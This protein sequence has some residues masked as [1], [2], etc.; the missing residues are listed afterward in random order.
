MIKFDSTLL[1]V[2]RVSL[3]RVSYGLKAKVVVSETA[4]SHHTVSHEIDHNLARTF[5]R[6]HSQ[7][8]YPLGCAALV[9]RYDDQ[10]LTVVR[11]PNFFVNDC[12]SAAGEKWAESVEN[13]FEYF[14]DSIR[15]LFDGHYFDGAN[16]ID[17]K[18]VQMV[19]SEGGLSFGTAKSVKI[20]S[21]LQVVA[22]NKMHGS[23]VTPSLFKA[24]TI[25]VMQRDAD[26][27]VMIGLDRSAFAAMIRGE[28][29]AKDVAAHM[30][31]GMLNLQSIET[32]VTSVVARYD[33]QY[34]SRFNLLDVMKTLGTLDLGRI[35]GE[36]KRAM[37]T[38]NSLNLMMQTLFDII[39]EYETTSA[40]INMFRQYINTVT[41]RGYEIP[42]YSTA[43]FADLV[44]SVMK[45]GA[46]VDSVPVIDYNEAFSWIQFT[47]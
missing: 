19:A 44:Q 21:L 28:N 23:Q 37:I 29:A 5:K 1:S 10:I 34:I 14:R 35:D 7:T 8:R 25:A 18:S 46:T 9:I 4:G 43:A 13:Y 39:H 2:E 45:P 6:R 36:I 3:K 47:I 16:I 22:D 24:L 17:P 31:G 20:S 38:K 41:A 33:A 12:E 15:P 30:Q 11:H 32:F 27:D 40:D 42:K 26:Q